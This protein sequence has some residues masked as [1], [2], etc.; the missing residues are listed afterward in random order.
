MIDVNTILIISGILFQ[1][2]AECR[3]SRCSEI[4]IGPD[5]IDLTRDV[6]EEEVAPP[7]YN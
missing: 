4:H 2:F 1:F 5:G 3:R 7:V 6:I